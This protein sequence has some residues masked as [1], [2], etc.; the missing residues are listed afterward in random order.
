MPEPWRRSWSGHVRR[1]AAPIR[2]RRSPQASAVRHGLRHRRVVAPRSA[3]TAPAARRAG[4]GGA[5]GQEVPVARLPRSGWARKGR[6]CR[7]RRAFPRA[8]GGT[9]AGPALAPSSRSTSPSARTAPSVSTC[10]EE[11]APRM[12]SARPLVAGA[13]APVRAEL[14]AIARGEHLVVAAS[15]VEQDHQAVQG[16]Q[17]IRGVAARGRF[18]AA[19][20]DPPGVGEHPGSGKRLPSQSRMS[21][22]THISAAAISVRVAPRRR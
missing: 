1:L 10:G 17:R 9:S 19:V 18:E 14:A 15:D 4:G 13:A 3:A 20:V 5:G 8:A 6:A 22:S 16:M 12:L 21:V 2:R 11:L 7:A